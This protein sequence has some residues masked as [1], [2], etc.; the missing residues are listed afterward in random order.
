MKNQKDFADFW[1]GPHPSPLIAYAIMDAKIHSAGRLRW[2]VM[3][4]KD[5]GTGRLA[6]RDWVRA[7]FLAPANNISRWERSSRETRRVRTQSRGSG[8]PCAL[9]TMRAT[10]RG[11][12]LSKRSGND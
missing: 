7:H 6:A 10:I 2:K 5:L 8:G 3:S 9:R 1:K 11:L 12:G 4:A